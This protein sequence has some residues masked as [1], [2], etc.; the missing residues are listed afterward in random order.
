MINHS[1][2]KFVKGSAYSAGFFIAG[3]RRL[4]VGS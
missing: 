3:F 2:H 4:G 1:N